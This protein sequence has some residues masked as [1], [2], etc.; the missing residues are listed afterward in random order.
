MRKIIV[1]FAFGQGIQLMLLWIGEKMTYSDNLLGFCAGVGAVILIAALIGFMGTLLEFGAMEREPVQVER[2]FN[3]RLPE[4]VEGTIK[5][6]FGRKPSYMEE[7]A[8]IP[9]EIEVTNT[10]IMRTK[11]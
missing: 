4:P 3:V 11:G 9:E 8:P 7:T 2:E 6:I 1:A 10:N 5:N